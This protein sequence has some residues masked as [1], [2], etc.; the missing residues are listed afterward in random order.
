MSQR[1]SPQLFKCEYLQVVTSAFKVFEELVGL[2][3]MQGQ[4]KGSDFIQ[5]LLCGLQ[6]RNLELSKL[7]DIFTD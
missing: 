2:H 1:A 4:T 7:V 6:E 5:T 3:S